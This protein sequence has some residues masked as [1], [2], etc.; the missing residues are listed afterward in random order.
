MMKTLTLDLGE[1]GSVWGLDEADE[2]KRKLIRMQVS[3]PEQVE[4]APGTN[5]MI[6]NAQ[7]QIVAK[8]FSDTRGHGW[9]KMHSRL[10]KCQIF[11]FKGLVDVSVLSAMGQVQPVEA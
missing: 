7:L 9:Q 6:N 5:S 8:V 3:K 2:V 10:D 4:F 1:K 11:A